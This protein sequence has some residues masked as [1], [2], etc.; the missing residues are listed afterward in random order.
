M[1][2]A[3]YFSDNTETIVRLSDVFREADFTL[4]A[5]GSLT[6]ARASMLRDAPDIALMDYELLGEEG[7]KFLE[8]SRL[9]NV[10]ELILVSEDPQL[11][12]AIRGMQAGASD[13]LQKPIDPDR[14]RGV[15]QR[16]SGL[17]SGPRPEDSGITKVG[18]LGIMH[19]DSPPMRRLF[20]MLR[21][22]ALT[23]MT[24][25][26]VG[27]S[28]VGKELAARI[29]HQLSERSSG[30]QV[31]VNCGAI[32]PE[33]LE[34]ELFGHEKG[35]FTG[36]SKRHTGFFERANEGTLF[37]DEITEMSSDLQ[38]RLL[39]VLETGRLRR[40]GGEKELPVDVRVVA[41]T[42]RDPTEALEQGKL[43]ED[44]YYR[45]AQFPLRV[46]TLRERGDD[47]LLLAER[48]LAEMGKE[49]GVE[50]R[51]SDEAVEL[52]R[53]HTWP[54]NV[55]E[56]RNAIGRAYVLAGEEIRPD[57][58]PPSVIEGRPV[59]SD[60]LRIAVGT[61]LQEVER[62]AILATVEHME[63][64]KKAAAEALGISLKTLYTKLKKYRGE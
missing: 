40:V 58:L 27:E 60:Y 42:N 18:G 11:R 63:G 41:A 23:D 4:T 59:E 10:I 31:P 17:V 19:G 6:E 21:K 48:F 1:L 47:I 2:N 16:V 5:V 24:V 22:V 14:L 45:L 20:K 15:L 13:Y 35:S 36:A 56:L 7:L 38:V 26:L 53:V 30:P 62:R 25:L 37:L 29:V 34:S 64:D 39:R 12:E 9:G 61:P 51:F 50:K 49:H 43:R 8:E 28:G 33:I 52:L 46:P 32:S 3:L 44:L 57:D 54:G 55:R